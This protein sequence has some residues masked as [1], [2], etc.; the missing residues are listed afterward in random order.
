MDAPLQSVREGMTEVDA[1]GEEV[2][3]VEFVKMGDPRA[4]TTHGSETDTGGLLRTLF[5]SGPG[6]PEPKRRQFLRYGYLQIDGPELMDS[7]RYVRGDRVSS[8]SNGLVVLSVAKE[9]LVDER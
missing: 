7:D 5:E 3:K 2:G 8:V 1:A 6:V 9:R 4:A